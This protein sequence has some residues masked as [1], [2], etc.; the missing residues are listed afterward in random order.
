MHVM[1]K[2]MMALGLVS[3]LAV[4]TPVATQAQGVYIQGPGVEF[5]IGR[6]YR[7]R[8]YYGYYNYDRPY[9]GDRYEYRDRY[10][11]RDWD[12]PRYRTYDWGWRW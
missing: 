12:G 2:T 8:D 3:G 11:G 9:Y 5:G 10:Y 7:D 1:A 4:A 6:P